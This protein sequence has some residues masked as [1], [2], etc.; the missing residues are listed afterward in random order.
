MVEGMTTRKHS[1]A[2]KNGSGR[3]K[4][5]SRTAF[6][7][8]E[9]NVDAI[10]EVLLEAAK[11]GNVMSTRLLFELA[12]RNVEVRKSGGK[13]PLL[14]LAMRLAAEP[15]LPPNALDEETDEEAASPEPARG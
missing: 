12:E 10:A 2:R 13:H 7:A 1:E 15:R 11:K 8:V 3:A 4:R 14:T 5:L 9:K 6:E